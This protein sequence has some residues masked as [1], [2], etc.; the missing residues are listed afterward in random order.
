[1]KH[2]PL[3]LFALAALGCETTT[4][5]APLPS[6]PAYALS[7]P[8][9]SGRA[10]TAEEF[11]A[12][13]QAGRAAQALRQDPRLRAQ[14]AYEHTQQLVNQHRS[15]V[16]ASSFEQLAWHALARERLLPAPSSSTRDAA[17]GTIARRLVE[18]GHP[19]A[20]LIEQL[21]PF[22]RADERCLLYTSPSPRD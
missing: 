4:D 18:L 16:Y 1:M 19:E 14:Q 20:A 17:L 5:P 12:Y 6:P 2:V 7:I 8:T 15:A 9:P 10:W 3:F 22:V 21:L 11:S 13:V